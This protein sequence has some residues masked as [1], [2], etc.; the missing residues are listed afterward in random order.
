MAQIKIHRDGTVET[1]C[2]TQDIGG[3]ARTVVL[4]L[5]SMEL[6]YLP[7]N[8]ITVKIGD[9]EFGASGASAGSSTTAGVLNEIREAAKRVLPQLYELVAERLRVDA[10][11]LTIREDGTIG[12]RRGDRGLPWKEAC[13]LINDTLIG[14][15][16]PPLAPD[17]QW[18]VM[19]EDGAVEQATEE[20]YKA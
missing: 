8:L 2:G 6:G 13:S 17:A 14:H 15:A 7:L 3:G 19:R 1:L 18:Y 12:P 10:G 5:T 9:S 16:G 4:V 20:D 11:D